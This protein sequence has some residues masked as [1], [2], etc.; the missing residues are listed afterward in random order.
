[1]S[2]LTKEVLFTMIKTKGIRILTIVIVEEQAGCVK[3]EIG[4]GRISTRQ[5]ECMLGERLRL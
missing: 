1:M 4:R 2:S 3:F 5:A